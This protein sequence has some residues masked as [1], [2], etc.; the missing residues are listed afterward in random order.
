MWECPF[1]RVLFRIWFM[2]LVRK[3]M[4]ILLN[5]QLV[6]PLRYAIY[7]IYNSLC[8]IIDTSN[9]NNYNSSQNRPTEFSELNP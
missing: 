6:E 3:Q 2:I 8:T 9:G 4:R 7:D 1:V 5:K